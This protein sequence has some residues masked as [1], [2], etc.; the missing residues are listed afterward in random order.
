MIPPTLEMKIIPTGPILA[1]S[2]ASY[3]APLGHQLG[4]EI[5][6]PCA[7]LNQFLKILAGERRMRHGL[8]GKAESGPIATPVSA[9][10]PK[11]QDYGGQK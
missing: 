4:V 9:G 1:I 10:L 11:V 3:P 7:V 8:I 2:W 6:L 5:Q